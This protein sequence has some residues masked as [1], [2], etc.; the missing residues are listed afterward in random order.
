MKGEYSRNGSDTGGF[1]EPADMEQSEGGRRDESDSCFRGD[2]CSS[3]GGSLLGATIVA[4]GGS[5]ATE[6]SAK[7]ELKIATSSAIDERRGD[8]SGRSATGVS[9]N[10]S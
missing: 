8:R 9:S 7:N 1:R 5:S 4:R 6:L 10:S 2:G 3:R